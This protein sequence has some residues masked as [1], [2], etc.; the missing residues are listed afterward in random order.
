MRWWP[1]GKQEEPEDDWDLN[2]DGWFDRRHGSGRDTQAQEADGKVPPAD[3]APPGAGASPP[4][5]T[6]QEGDASPAAVHRPQ[7]AGQV[8]SAAAIAPAVSRAQNAGGGS[9]DPELEAQLLR[10]FE[11]LEAAEFIQLEEVCAGL[12]G[13]VGEALLRAARSWN[14]RLVDLQKAVSQ[15]IEQGARP[16]LAS[17]RLAA[18]ARMLDQQIVQLA[19]LSE[20]LSASVTEVAAS[21]DEAARGAQEALDQVQS[22]MDRIQGALAGMVESGRAVEE[23]RSHV[24]DLAGSVDPIRDVLGLIREVADQTNLLALNAAI[25]AARAGEHGRGFAV[26]ADEVRRL[27]E[28]TNEA[29]RDVQRRIDALQDGTTRVGEAMEEMGRRMSEGVQLAEAGQQALQQMRADLE[30]GLRPIKDIATAADEQ[31]QAVSQATESAEKIALAATGIKDSA[32][33]LA[34]MVADLQATL[35]GLR[36]S[37]GTM[38]LQ[39]QDEDLLEL[40]K[41]DHVLWVQRLHGMILGR[42]QIREEQV[43]DH[44]RCR[45]G[46]WYYGRGRQ[47][48]GHDA[49]FRSLEEPHRRLHE[50]AAKTVAAWNAGH[51]EEATTL[52][53]QVVA[54]S[55]EILSILSQLQTILS[56]TAR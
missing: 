37:A 30:Q 29:V 31:A 49:V 12:P 35:G 17:H 40:A 22:G 2:L 38:Q 8:P 5:G 27:A 52:M 15:A 11:C 4:D 33:S 42:Q 44:T 3:G 53:Q 24:Q 34:E 36:E 13:A 1:F 25:E 51:H 16:L 19:A 54:T 43:A 26:V 56:G 9:M 47:R 28:R 14:L 32:A 55:Q 23:L 6:S 21:A 10:A 50:T 45:L 46:R 18:D 7:P 41:A 20:E 39:L 48:L